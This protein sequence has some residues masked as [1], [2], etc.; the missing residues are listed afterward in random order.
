MI[1]IPTD[2]PALKSL[3][4]SHQPNSP[5]LWAVLEGRHSGVALVDQAHNLDQCVLRTDAALTYLSAHTRQAFLEASIQHFRQGGPVWLVWPHDTNLEPPPAGQAIVIPRLEFYDC[6]PQSDTLSRW[7]ERLP[8]GF[9]IRSID[10]PLFQRCEWREEMAFYAGGEKN[11]LAQDIGL[12]LLHGEEIIAEA[13]ASALG[14][15]L[16]EIGAITRQPHR[17]RE[18]API[19]CAYL[20]QLCHQRGYQ[21]YWSCDAGHSAS[22]RVARKLGF[23]REQSYTIYE[24]E[25]LV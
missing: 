4:D 23:R 14:D 15:T 6:D 12:C 13:Y 17:G 18:Y 20:I 16:A 9:E 11:F 2:H 21:A 8:A 25:D 19:A 3:F 7:R 5:A 1:E 22:I 10:A 24:F